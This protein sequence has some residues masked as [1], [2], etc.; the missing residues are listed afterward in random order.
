[1]TTDQAPDQATMR[2]YA[3]EQANAYG[4]D[5]DAYERQITQE[6]GWRPGAVSSA[7]AQG[8]AQ[9][10][11]DTARAEG[12][13]PS[14]WKQS[15]EGGARYQSKQIKYFGG[16]VR[17]GTAAYNAGAGTVEQAKR[18]YG[19]AW[20]E[21]LPEETKTYLARIVDGGPGGGAGAATGHG[22]G[23]GDAAANVLG[24]G[25][26]QLMSMP[27]PLSQDTLAD[28][29]YQ[30]M[31]Q[32]PP[33]TAPQTPEDIAK[34]TDWVSS[35][36]QD[37][38]KG[39]EAQVAEKK[40]QQDELA[41]SPTGDPTLD[42]IY[43]KTSQLPPTK[44]LAGEP[45]E[46]DQLRGSMGMD[47]APPPIIQG[48]GEVE[49]DPY[50]Q[51]LLSSTLGGTDPKTQAA[52]LRVYNETK[53]STGSSQTAYWNMLNAKTVL[54]G[55]WSPAQWAS[56]QD[57]A[58]GSGKDKSRYGPIFQEFYDLGAT[59]PDPIPGEDDP[60]RTMI[61]RAMAGGL[62]QKQ[63]QDML[64]NYYS[65]MRLNGDD[66]QQAFLQFKGTMGDLYGNAKAVG[67]LALS[68]TQFAEQYAPAIILGTLFGGP[69]G[70][71]AG[72]ASVPGIE[73][74]N[75]RLPEGTP[76]AVETAIDFGLYGITADPEQA[77]SHPLQTIAHSAMSGILGG[78]GEIAGGALEGAGVPH[79]GMAGSMLFPVLSPQL[80][81]RAKAGI[82]NMSMAAANGRMSSEAVQ[83]ELN[84]TI[85][86]LGPGAKGR[87]VYFGDSRGVV[88]DVVDENTVRVRDDKTGATFELRKDQVLYPPG[89][90]TKP[91]LDA[92]D[93]GHTVAWYDPD[94][95]ANMP[96]R[97]Q[98][99]LATMVNAINDGS[100]RIFVLDNENNKQ[101]WNAWERTL[102]G[103]LDED[104][105]RFSTAQAAGKTNLPNSVLGRMF[106]GAKSVALQT[107]GILYRTMPSMLAA[108]NLQKNDAAATFTK[109]AWF[110]RGL[111]EAFGDRVIA[112][113][114]GQHL[115][116]QFTGDAKEIT[117]ARARVI[118]TMVDAIEHPDEY[119]LSP[120]QTQVLNA[121][122]IMLTHDVALNRAYGV[123]MGQTARAY[124]P[125]QAA[126]AGNKGW[127]SKVADFV[128]ESP[129]PG[130]VRTSYQPGFTKTREITDI[131]SWA[132]EMETHNAKFPGANIQ[133][134][135]DPFKLYE[136]RLRSSSDLR[137]RLVFTRGVASAHG[138]P[139]PEGMNPQEAALKAGID[140]EEAKTYTQLQT[141]MEAD[142]VAAR[143]DLRSQI[144]DVK[145]TI[146]TQRT[147]A[148]TQST[149]GTVQ[150][151]A[152]GRMN[153]LLTQTEDLLDK[154]LE[155]V[156]PG[157]SSP[158]MSDIREQAFARIEGQVQALDREA[159]LQGQMSNVQGSAAMESE[160][161]LAETTQRLNE[162]KGKLGDLVDSYMQT[163]RQVAVP[164]RVANEANSFLAPS[165]AKVAD[166]AATVG[167]H[168]VNFYKSI[169]LSMDSSFLTRHGYNLASMDPAGY[170]TNMA[171]NGLHFASEEGFASFLTE[172][173][174]AV[175]DFTLHGGNLWVDPAGI[176][177]DVGG[178]STLM[179]HIPVI[180]QVK[181]FNDAAFG[182]ALPV[183]KMYTY[184]SMVQMLL[185]LKA[186]Q[187]GAGLDLAKAPIPWAIEHTPGANR[188]GRF[189]S[190]DIGSW[191][192]DQVKKAAADT[193]NNIGGGVDM[194]RVNPG[195][196]AISKLIGDASL[197]SE[198]WFRANM[199]NIIQLANVHDPRGVLAR[200][201]MFQQLAI[202]A[203]LSTAI[204]QKF[205]T[206]QTPNFNPTGTD[207]M[208]AKIGDPTKPWQ[209]YSVDMLPNKA[210]VRTALRE[211]A[212]GV[213]AAGLD[214]RGAG[215]DQ[216][217]TNALDTM[218][219]F[220]NGK[221]GQFMQLA[222]ELTD[223]AGTKGMD[224][225][226]RQ[227]QGASDYAKEFLPIWMQSGYDAL[228]GQA[229]GGVVPTLGQLSAHTVIPT[230]PF[231]VRDNAITQAADAGR[232]FKDEANQTG[233]YITKYTDLAPWQ[234]E[235]F[236]RLNP[237]YAQAIKQ[238]R[239]ERGMPS[240]QLAAINEAHGLAVESLGKAFR[241]ET[242]SKQD[243]D[244]IAPALRGQSLQPQDF[245]RNGEAYGKALGSLALEYREQSQ[246]VGG[247]AGFQPPTSGSYTAQL[248]QDY[249]KVVIDA[250]APGGH[251]D[252]DLLD[253]N[254]RYF[255]DQVL[256]KYGAPG[257]A[258]LDKLEVYHKSDDVVAS[259]YH[260]DQKEHIDPFY[261][262]RDLMW[263]PGHLQ[264]LG[265]A[266]DEIKLATGGV[267]KT[268]QEYEKHFTDALTQQLVSG[269]APPTSGNQE[270]AKYYTDRGITPGQRLSPE[271]AGE[272]SLYLTG[273]KF[274][275]Y[276]KD[277]LAWD[278]QYLQNHPMT[279]CAMGYWQ[280]KKVP[281]AAQAILNANV[282]PV[283]P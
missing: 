63:D 4:I 73:E 148:N 155:H 246:K 242:L 120:F 2:A 164:G 184:Q 233:A 150:R 200:R 86:S 131:R 273:K 8:L 117:G 126:D 79:A 35:M 39:V 183:A 128:S 123:S 44:R 149:R 59:K 210:Y 143:A 20:E 46:A 261:T 234:Q 247:Q 125:H 40:T 151:Q 221:E 91:T 169:R 195:R 197:L 212:A 239:E 103:P 165:A 208:D 97:D 271:G 172:H 270:L 188:I 94:S 161:R 139:V 154:A 32:G 263:N 181:G 223:V 253:S 61:I 118:G 13:D 52:L 243:L 171:T 49:T 127:L 110:K 66:P 199:G 152:Q 17:A 24:S 235:S 28:P 275:Q 175:Q 245:V 56:L 159:N 153:A 258:V 180:S 166:R 220:G 111:S 77:L 160:R 256:K 95:V 268:Q 30:K 90:G 130:S 115:L 283:R 3:R 98:T 38:A 176:T 42:A 189:L 55:S 194:M 224:F 72:A 53:R 213:E 266:P 138:I 54:S 124:V 211:I 34:N 26:G 92:P 121:W 255:R 107:S 113:P 133:P 74:V 10:M 232:G 214:L 251:L 22:F 83:E 106:I 129:A 269:F 230:S 25:I 80:A 50:Q 84:K 217:H 177:H 89:A 109:M 276:K 190:G 108:S 62:P 205:G 68:P 93:T 9:F 250:S 119:R 75:N 236:D 257:I 267:Y 146:K 228:T 274:T 158:G 11:P 100:S 104:A 87:V 21:H 122:D 226:G 262:N 178:H 7:G 70:A 101:L 254:K 193:A 48:V 14:D 204:S 69:L 65:T 218:L 264:N 1:M 225:N 88:T 41:K 207:F 96:I 76:H 198:N 196:H 156:S 16:D 45:T 222:A 227:L 43:E 116:G 6:S 192:V 157:G 249:Y 135:L 209:S 58:F 167:Q 141:P 19:L 99:Q 57:E 27:K 64:I 173:M 203:M 162:L 237:Q 23:A 5:P 174:A 186:A 244:L 15:L 238:Y 179:D 201:F 78:T 260:Q 185:S 67:P 144:S 281:A 282:C 60:I 102:R 163:Q 215:I 272:L 265:W 37:L 140:P 12:I 259:Q 278:V 81:A 216:N 182:R 137:S 187:S 71:V 33:I 51:S 132:D 47:A 240:A 134:E 279:T 231:E 248:V 105:M 136:Q 229:G 277:E 241:G 18:Q 29:L 280:P 219:R 85:Q 82:F 145:A 114:T 112:D 206:G 252:F 202:T 31:Q 142:V 191:T 168:V 36:A 170:F 147:L